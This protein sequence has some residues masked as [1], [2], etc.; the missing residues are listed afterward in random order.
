[1]ILKTGVVIFILCRLMLPAEASQQPSVSV[2]VPTYWQEAQATGHIQFNEQLPPEEW[3]TCF[4]DPI[5]SDYIHQALQANQDL[6]TAENRIKEAKGIAQYTFG[7]ELPKV[8]LVA[9]DYW[10]K[11]PELVDNPIVPHGFHLKTTS[12]SL[13]N[14][15]IQ[16]SYEVD[17]FGKNRALTKAARMQT[18]ASEEDYRAVQLLVTATLAESYFNLL[19]A[20]K[21]LQLQQTL[22]TLSES[23]LQMHCKRYEEGLEPYDTVLAG[24][25]Q[26]A[27]TEA[28]L[29]ETERLQGLTVHQIRVLMGQ[30]P[31]EQAQF[32]RNTLDSLALFQGVDTGIPVQ[33]LAHRPDIMENEALLESAGFNVT[34]ARRAFFPTI[35][36]SDQSGSAVAV[37]EHLLSAGSFYDIVSATLTQSLFTGGQKIANLKIQKARYQE[38]LHQYG[39]TILNALQEAEDALS[40]LKS[41][42]SQYEEN[43]NTVDAADHIVSLIQQRYTEGVDSNLDF[44]TGQQQMNLYQQQLAQ[45]KGQIFIDY[46]S[47]YK[48][49]GG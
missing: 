34:A 33:L 4:H 12:F 45:T 47:L 6:K 16:A 23:M 25:E 18:K 24:Q 44:L 3:W 43:A 31:V 13:Y 28:N 10:I 20:D 8:N 48:A 40:D 39:Q 38:Q 5:L 14:L 15:A 7:N 11:L 32:Q 49:V 26:V 27:L 42:T 46:V 37:F 30:P 36:L 35:V 22:L 2:P 19:K 9:S 1:M 29:E 17:L 21:L 41:H